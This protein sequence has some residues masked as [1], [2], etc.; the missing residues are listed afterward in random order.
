MIKC[1][2]CGAENEPIF[3]YCLSCGK[4]LEQS[5]SSFKPRPAKA[6]T[7]GSYSLFAVRADGG[8]GT[9]YPLADGVNT[10]GAKGPDVV[11]KDDP[12][13][14]DQHATVEIGGDV[15]FIEDLGTRHG[16]YLR[17]RDEHSLSTNDQLRVG[18]AL[19]QLEIKKKTPPPAPDGSAWLG[20]SGHK[21]DFFG[22]LLR[23]GPEDVVI[24]AHL[25]HAPE[26]T[27]GR[28]GGDI[29]MPDDP[30][31]SSR[32]AAFVWT[33]NTCLLK[34]L[35]STNGCY[36][37]AKGRVAFKEGDHILLGHHVFLYKQSKKDKGS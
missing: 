30:F 36:L 16:T 29:L 24:Q 11:I 33:G 31:V 28:T 26:T 1:V 22:R 6:S 9:E 18:H 17:I 20:S 34:D 37:R 3:T 4:P 25:L 12:R 35:G 13:V 21:G 19:Y 5:L 23:L 7:A 32:H 8:I 10:L 15:A 2:H 27:L 14:A